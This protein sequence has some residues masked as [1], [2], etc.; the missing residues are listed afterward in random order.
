MTSIAIFIPFLW[1]FPI[2]RP[3]NTVTQNRYEDNWTFV[4]RGSTRNITVHEESIYASFKNLRRPSVHVLRDLHEKWMGDPMAYASLRGVYLCRV[5]MS[6]KGNC[7]LISPFARC[8]RWKRTSHCLA[9]CWS[10][11]KRT[12]PWVVYGQLYDGDSADRVISEIW[13]VDYDVEARLPY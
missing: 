6:G 9:F 10:R 2:N 11:T 8:Y 7:T 3:R 4:D 13:N 1:K 5:E 12:R